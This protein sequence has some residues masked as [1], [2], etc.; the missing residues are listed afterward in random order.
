MASVYQESVSVDGGRFRAWAATL[1][2]TRGLVLL[3][4]GAAALRFAGLGGQSFWY[5]EATT[6]SVIHF[7]WTH[8]LLTQIANSES[9]PPLYY[10]LVKAWTQVFGG[11]AV[12]LRSFSA[13]AGTGSVA[14]AY[15]IGAELSGR[16]LALAAGTLTALN[17][18]LIWYS[19]EARSYELFVLLAGLSVLFFLKLRSDI[20]SPPALQERRTGLR[21]HAALWT[22]VSALALAT[23]YYAGF[24]IAA[25]AAWLLWD[26]RSRATGLREVALACVPLVAVQAALLP[27]LIHQVHAGHSSWIDRLDL[28]QRTGQVVIELVTFNAGLVNAVLAVKPGGG[29]AL[30][31]MLAV[32]AGAFGI[33]RA[34][35]RRRTEIGAPAALAAAVIA[36]PL[37][38]ALVASGGFYDRNLIGAWIP[39]IVVLAIGLTMLPQPLRVGALALL[40]AVS[41]ITDIR[42]GVDTRLQRPPWSAVAADM[43]PR[44]SARAVLL[45]PAWQLPSLTYYD[46]RLEPVDVTRPVR[47]LDVIA[48]DVDVRFLPGTVGP[49]R[50]S[51]RRQQG[52]LAFVRLLAAQP[53]VVSSAFLAQTPLGHAGGRLLLDPPGARTVGPA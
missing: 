41:L 17:P 13:L 4:V 52:S 37:A 21:A 5:D 20:H 22:I 27:L 30:A 39:L 15:L 53:T 34:G 26:A 10:L 2:A 48:S 8:G 23:H 25:E 28:S 47:E 12:G 11:G 3:L 44:T 49:F 1:V 32:G 29:W 46:E 35:P 14:V 33:H 9:T 19:Q 43:T 16:R 40:C 51:E 50:V 38:V 45:Y 24:L 31:A 18:A 6:A 42:L 7:G 36:I